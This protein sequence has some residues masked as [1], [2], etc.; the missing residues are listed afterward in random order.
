MRADHVGHRQAGEFGDH[1]QVGPV[2]ADRHPNRP[3]AEGRWLFA[4]APEN[5]LHRILSRQFVEVGLLDLL[6]H[7]LAFRHVSLGLHI[8]QMA[9]DEIAS[10]LLNIGDVFAHDHFIDARQ[11]CCCD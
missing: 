11:A 2:V 8:E 1:V 5:D 9:E 7:D 6:G 10:G 3:L 4:C